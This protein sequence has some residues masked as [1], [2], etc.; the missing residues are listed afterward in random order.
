MTRKIALSLLVCSLALSGC[1]KIKLP[2]FGK[3]KPATPAPAVVQSE[4]PPPPSAASAPA[5]PAT[6][7]IDTHAGVMVL[8][9]HNIEDKGGTKALTI[10]VAEFEEQLTAVKEH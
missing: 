7:V 1:G 6:P 9:Y 3:K 8:C 10:S 5:E 2:T 4:P